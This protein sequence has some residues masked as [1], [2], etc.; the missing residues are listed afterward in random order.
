MR[1]SEDVLG[2]IVF[3]WVLR[4]N[5]ARQ[6]SGNFEWE[7]REKCTDV[8]ETLKGRTRVIERVADLRGNALQILYAHD[9]YIYLYI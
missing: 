3:V 4:P 1:Q 9:I 8:E 6:L 7:R 2:P 5:G